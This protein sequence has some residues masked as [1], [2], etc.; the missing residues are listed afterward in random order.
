MPDDLEIPVDIAK[1]L[2]RLVDSLDCL[3]VLVLLHRDA[4]RAWAPNEV[5]DALGMTLRTARRELERLAA[6]GVAA[7]EGA[8]LYRLSP[9]DDERAEDVRRIVEAHGTRRI[10][11]INHVASRALKR[12]QSLAN[13]FRIKKGDSDD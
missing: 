12:I 7:D 6:R 13:A 5:A 4:S 2:D 10:G 9:A 1:S 3:E 8:E 11:V